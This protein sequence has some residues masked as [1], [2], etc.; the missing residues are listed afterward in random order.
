MPSLA[1]LQFHSILEKK[2]EKFSQ[3]LQH[4]FAK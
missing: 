4:F 1:F 3:K 2:G